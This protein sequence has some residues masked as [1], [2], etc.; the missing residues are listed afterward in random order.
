MFNIELW[1]LNDSPRPVAA[2]RVEAV[3][4]IDGAEHVVGGWDHP[5]TAAN[6]NLAGPTVNIV[7]PKA[8]PG[9]MQLLLRTPGQ[10]DL[11]STYTVLLG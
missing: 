8:Q 9:R 10:P 5:G 3:L 6:T 2:G 7:L 11:Y 1:L 4:M